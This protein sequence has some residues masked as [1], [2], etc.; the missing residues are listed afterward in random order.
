MINMCTG[1]CRR[2][3]DLKQGTGD[4]DDGTDEDEDMHKHFDR[5]K[6]VRG[7]QFFQNHAVSCL[8][9]MSFSLA[10][11]LSV[12]NLLEVLVATGKSATPKDSLR[13]YMRTAFHVIKW[14]YGNIWN[15]HTLSGKS[16]RAVRQIHNN[17]R[18]FMTEKTEQDGNQGKQVWVSQYDMSLVQCGFMGAII[19]YPAEFGIR[20]S[21]KDLDDY[22]YFWKWVG[23]FLGIKDRNNICCGGYDEVYKLC[24]E[25]EKNILLPAMKDPPTMFGPMA[26]A[27]IKG[28]RRLSYIG[29]FSLDEILMLTFDQMGEKRIRSVS[30]PDRLRIIF[31]RT[32][33][34]LLYYIPGLSW[35]L[36]R[37]CATVFGWS[38]IT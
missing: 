1:T 28:G 4:F 10:C 13:R 12:N 25:I 35:C 2:L 21:K 34:N 8:L 30:I 38:K 36:S 20:C 17:V 14:H 9:A 6:F 24:K 26:E 11:G 15:R 33:V 32:F 27:F 19:M 3:E 37:L 18:Q 5:Q 7:Q 29:L 22:V 23:H 16:V 31:F